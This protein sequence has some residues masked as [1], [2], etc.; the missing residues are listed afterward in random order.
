MLTFATK[1]WWIT[2]YRE[3]WGQVLWVDKSLLSVL[4]SFQSHVREVN[5]NVNQAVCLEGKETSWTVKCLRGPQVPWP[6]TD[7]KHLNRE[8]LRNLLSGGCFAFFFFNN[9]VP[10][11]HRARMWRRQ[12]SH[13]ICAFK[14]VK[15]LLTF[16]L[17]SVWRL[18][19][20]DTFQQRSSCWNN[21]MR[22]ST[23]DSLLL[24]K[25][26]PHSFLRISFSLYSDLETL[27]F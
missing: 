1:R 6:F 24:V 17:S 22:L 19:S 8:L 16:P 5:K 23:C 2:Y 10:E 26:Y 21:S 25:H 13:Y 4:L 27:L 15:A 3:V 18:H 12:P 20:A 14:V 9:W 11:G 7:C